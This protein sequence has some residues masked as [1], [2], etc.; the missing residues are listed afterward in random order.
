MGQS[1]KTEIIRTIAEIGRDFDSVEMSL[2][3]EF[4]LR[5][6][7]ELYPHLYQNSEKIGV[8][9]RLLEK[10]EKDSGFQQKLSYHAEDLKFE[11]IA[12]LCFQA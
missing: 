11:K 2:V 7:E 1:L 8:V 4:L 12:N 5:M 10:L 9:N 3:L 6:Y